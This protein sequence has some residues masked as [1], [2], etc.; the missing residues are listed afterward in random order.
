[1]DGSATPKP[2]AGEVPACDTTAQPAPEPVTPPEPSASKPSP[3]DPNIPPEPMP[4]DRLGRFFED[5]ATAGTA[6]TNRN[7]TLWS[8]VSE[9]LRNRPY[10]PEN[11]TNDAASALETAMLNAQEAW[12][13]MVRAPERER[14]A[15]VLPTAL[16]VF[17]PRVEDSGGGGK[18]KQTICW[19]PVDPVWMRVRGP[20][21]DKLPKTAKIELSGDRKGAEALRSCLRTCLGSSRQAYLLRVDN[22]G[23]LVPGV[24]AGTVYLDDPNVRPIANLRIIVEEYKP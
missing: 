6:M 24:Y 20:G 23:T 18:R 16:L 1:M 17:T 21:L 7:L 15:D 10:K 11:L 8:T 5:L 14:V 13:S 9:N 12:E 22:V 19:D 2:T 4:W 3:P